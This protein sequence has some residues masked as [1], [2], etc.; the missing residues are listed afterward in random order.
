MSASEKHVVHHHPFQDEA[1]IV[2]GDEFNCAINSAGNAKCWGFNS[3]GQLLIGTSEVI[4]GWPSRRLS[5]PA[6]L[7]NPSSPQIER[8]PFK[9]LVVERERSRALACH[10]GWP[11]AALYSIE[12]VYSVEGFFQV[13]LQVSS[14]IRSLNSTN[15]W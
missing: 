14:K 13:R 11:D 12:R 8:V 1:Q 6:A 4:R 2:A 5:E 15:L 3:D 7:G 9:F 10:K